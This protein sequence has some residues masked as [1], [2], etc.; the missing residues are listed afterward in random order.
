MIVARG[1]FTRRL[2][3]AWL[4]LAE[5]D[6]DLWRELSDRLSEQGQR[7]IDSFIRALED[8]WRCEDGSPSDL[9]EVYLTGAIG[10][11]LMQTALV[12]TASQYQ[13]Q[14]LEEL[15]KTDPFGEETRALVPALCYIVRREISAELRLRAASVLERCCYWTETDGETIAPECTGCLLVGA[16]D[17]DAQVRLKALE[18]FTRRGDWLTSWDVDFLVDAYLSPFAWVATAESDSALDEQEACAGV[19]AGI[20]P[21]LRAPLCA[22]LCWQA[23]LGNS[24]A[25]NTLGHWGRDG[26]KCCYQE[27]AV[28][29][30][31]TDVTLRCAVASALLRLCS[32]RSE[33]EDAMGLLAMAAND[34]NNE[35]RRFVAE[36]LEESGDCGEKAEGI[37][38]A[39]LDDGNPGVRWAAER[40]REA[41]LKRCG[42]SR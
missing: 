19:L 31:S 1:S 34:P 30:L 20:R 16:F 13:S 3:R 4:V 28:G 42:G 8:A 39:L 33:C 32:S 18:A 25:V 2:L 6:L 29:M 9:T 27:V 37:I 36:A 21:E 23:A 41:F 24:T 12:A 5:R 11:P 15:G 26:L 22:V 40:A 10:A 7:A 38:G 14:I 17:E 35:L